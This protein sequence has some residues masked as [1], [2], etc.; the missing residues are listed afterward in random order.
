MVKTIKPKGPR[1]RK[2]MVRKKPPGPRK[3]PGPTALKDTVHV[4]GEGIGQKMLVF[5]FSEDVI[6]RLLELHDQRYA[7]FYY[8]PRDMRKRRIRLQFVRLTDL[9]IPAVM[10]MVEP[11]SYDPRGRLA[12][13]Q[14][15]RFVCAVSARRLGLRNGIPKRHPE[16]Y[17]AE[18]M[19]ALVINFHDED[20]LGTPPPKPRP[21][22]PPDL[23]ARK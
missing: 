20:M 18:N 21:G 5:T 16:W 4:V 15:R 19:L 9:K 12:R 7:A 22:D 23:V 14:Q 13:K 3:P 1:G 10:I 11:P 8:T 6:D 17:W 2:R